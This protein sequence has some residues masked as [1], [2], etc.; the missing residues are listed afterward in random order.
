MAYTL[1]KSS[2]KKPLLFP[3][4]LGLYCEPGGFYIDPRRGVPKALIT[5]AHSDHARAGSKAYFCALPCVPLLRNRL[6][7]R[8]SISGVPYAEETKIGDVTVSFHPA[9]HI[10][11]SSQIRVE[12]GGDVWV[13]SGDYKRAD[14]PTCAQF[15]PIRCNTFI[16]ESTFGLPIYRW[17]SGACIAREILGWWDWCR[18]AGRAA[19][20]YS[21]SLGKAQRILAE[22][23]R[24]SDRTV[25]VHETIQSVVACYRAAG[26]RMLP[27]LPLP[28]ESL[29][30]VLSGQLI[31]APPNAGVPRRMKRADD[32]ETAFASGWMMTRSSRRFGGFDRGFI[33]SDHADW[34]ALIQTVRESGA[35]RVLVTHGNWKPMVQYLREQGVEAA[36]LDTP[37][38]DPLNGNDE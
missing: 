14:D 26:I 4:P 7:T 25:S 1:R 23:A 34:P 32:Y 27:T 12:M 10:L 20:L 6:G 17:D 3:T 35:E 38:R 16:T 31:L 11:G 21:Y 9:G 5:H 8:A 33:L 2:H 37:A 29:D 24:I 28:E 19:I 22:L 15:E 36:P 30:Q 18:E 13:L